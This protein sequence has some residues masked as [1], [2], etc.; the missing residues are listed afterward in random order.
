[1]VHDYNKGE[2]EREVPKLA[3]G[4]QA[5]ISVVDSQEANMRNLCESIDECIIT[6]DGPASL[7]EDQYIACLSIGA[8]WDEKDETESEKGHER[9]LWS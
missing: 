4:L 8:I 3:H 6:K 5:V 7:W 1:M 2:R 9:E